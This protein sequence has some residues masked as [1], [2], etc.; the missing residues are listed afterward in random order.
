MGQPFG[1]IFDMDGV[2]VD[3]T[4]LHLRAFQQLGDKLGVP[5]TKELLQRTFGMHNNEILPLWLGAKLGASLTQARVQEL[6]D[7]KESLYRS[8]AASE[9]GPVPGVL[10]LVERLRTAGHPIAIGSSGPKQNVALAIERL[11]LKPHLKA[12]VTGH[13][14]K[15]GKPDPE[16]FVKAAA[17]L[18]LPPA[19]CVVFEDAVVGVEAALSAGC[20]AVAI[21]TSNPREKLLRAHLV[22]DEFEPLTLAKLQSLF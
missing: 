17:G 4:V 18:G 14:I 1:A 10:G 16:V 15:H 19:Q 12:V 11:G 7:E 3:S 22:V 8:L 20:K 6:A 13:D 9:L 5:F 21:T 2:L